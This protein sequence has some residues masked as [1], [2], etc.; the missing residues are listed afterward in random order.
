MFSR[1]CNKNLQS[2]ALDVAKETVVALAQSADLGIQSADIAR[3]KVVV[4]AF[5]PLFVCF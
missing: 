2:K 1:F 5:A 4:C 3:E